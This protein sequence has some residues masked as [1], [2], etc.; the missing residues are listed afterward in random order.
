V[1]LNDLS[2]KIRYKLDG[3]ASKVRVQKPHEKAFV[4]LQGAIGREEI[5]DDVLLQ[6]MTAMVNYASR[7][8]VALEE[9]S[10]RGSKH[11]IVAVE[12]LKLRR[13][14]AMGHWPQTSSTLAQ[15][16]GVG[17]I[18]AARLMFNGITGFEDVIASSD[19]LLE[20]SAK[21]TPP[22]G[23][24]LKNVVSTILSS[25]LKPVAHVQYA[26]GDPR[27]AQLF[28]R[29]EPQF[30][31]SHLDHLRI[32]GK[33]SQSDLQYTIFVYFNRPGGCRVYLRN[34]S[35]PTTISFPCHDGFGRVTID[36]VASL[37]G[38]DGK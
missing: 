30:N 4:L 35:A 7:M 15:L 20:E 19:K 32:S 14:L 24:K 37:L 5:N 13:S 12:S 36:L 16:R 27:L 9:Y 22:F 11:G 2:K 26:T 10:V 1:V 6:E 28:C 25:A 34:V 31:D 18:T 33:T 21:R 17:H 23:R 38:L 8:L 29:L 3:A